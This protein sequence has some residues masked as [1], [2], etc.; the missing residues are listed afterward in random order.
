[1]R[2]AERETLVSAV[3]RDEPGSARGPLT[4][5]DEFVAAVRANAET[6]RFSRTIVAEKDAAS[7]TKALHD[8]GMGGFVMCR[9][10]AGVF[11][12][13]MFGIGVLRC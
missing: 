5:P 2:F 12:I 6:Q 8:P 7:S 1:M 3:E 4:A 10:G 13:G 9:C 11:G